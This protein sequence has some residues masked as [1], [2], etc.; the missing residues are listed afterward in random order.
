MK[1]NKNEKYLTLK[2]LCEIFGRSEQ[3]VR[4]LVRERKIPFCK[5]GRTLLF[6][7]SVISLWLRDPNKVL[8]DWWN[9]DLPN[10]NLKED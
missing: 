9:P 5:F 10:N 8:T 1:E 7:K 2:Q 4:T 6:P 3:S